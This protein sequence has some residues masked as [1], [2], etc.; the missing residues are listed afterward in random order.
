MPIDADSYATI[1][2]LEALVGDIP[3]NTGTARTFSTS[4]VP[5]KVQAESFIDS[6]AAEINVALENTGYVNPILIANDKAAFNYI[7]HANAC[8]AALLVLG[9]MPMEAYQAPGQTGPVGRRGHYQNVFLAALRTIENEKLT[10]TR[11]SGG[12][13]LGDLR[14]GSEKNSDGETNLPLFKRGKTDYSGSRSLTE[15]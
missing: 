2:Q 6:V 7:A 4:T 13:H 1:A 14:V 8:G 9:T 10:A 12:T 11:L 15:A 5:T 3:I